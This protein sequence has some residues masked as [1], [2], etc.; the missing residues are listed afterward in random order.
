MIPRV[1]PLIVDV[2]RKTYSKRIV[3]VFERLILPTLLLSSIYFIG[4]FVNAA[5]GLQ[6]LITFIEREDF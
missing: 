2:S 4:M 1:H 6:I 5:Q 3:I